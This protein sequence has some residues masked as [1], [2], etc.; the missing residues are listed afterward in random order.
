M[1]STRPYRKALEHE[2]AISEIKRCAGTQ[3]DPTIA[4][5]FVRV[6]DKIDEARINPEEVYD[7]YSVLARSVKF[8]I[9]SEATPQSN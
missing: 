8:K 4:A 2:Y 7:Q 3:F 1:T 5:A 6:A 9:T